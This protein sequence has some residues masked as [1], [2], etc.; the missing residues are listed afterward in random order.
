MK[1]YFSFFKMRFLCGLQYRVA[2]YAGMSTQFAWGFLMILMFRA[3]YRAAPEKFPMS[4]PA[5]ST[6]IWLQQALL[7]L[8]MAHLFENELFE[9]ITSGN[10]AYE[11]CRPAS[12]YN[13][14]FARSLAKRLSAVALRCG[15]VLV[16]GLLLRSPFRLLLPD[17]LLRF[18]LFLF[19][20][21]LGLLVL[22]SINMLIYISA[23]YTISASGIRLLYIFTVDLFS[24]LI[25][26][27]PFL[28]D[29][30]RWIFELLPFASIQNTPF[31][32]YNGYLNLHGALW[33]VA[34]QLLWCSVILAFG[35]A[36]MKRAEKRLVVQGG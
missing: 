33:R 32:I 31:L 34:L 26:P 16:V 17:S 5:L 15:P 30:I 25:I 13:L 24:G 14:W 9:S 11:L 19:S 12:I 7:A 18:F 23:F 1:A 36:W 27:L 3:F 10:I 20:L 22:V 35:R 2:A 6:Y 28:P 21:G 4:F 29:R 8:I